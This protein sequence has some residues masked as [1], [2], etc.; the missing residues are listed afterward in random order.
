MVSRAW[1]AGCRCARR[2]VL[3]FP[4]GLWGRV[5]GIG[6]PLISV[7][8]DG[9]PVMIEPIQAVLIVRRGGVG[10][11]EVAKLAILMI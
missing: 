5:E 2:E 8:A 6:E 10:R 7:G 3:S 4:L 11:G 1:S 9:A